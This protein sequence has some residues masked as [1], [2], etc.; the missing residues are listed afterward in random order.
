VPVPFIEPCDFIRLEVLDNCIDHIGFE[1]TCILF[2]TKGAILTGTL[3][4]FA[5][6]SAQIF[7]GISLGKISAAFMSGLERKNIPI[8]ETRRGLLPKSLAPE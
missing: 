8:S 1:L 3:L 6:K 7:L 4:T 2:V 5:V